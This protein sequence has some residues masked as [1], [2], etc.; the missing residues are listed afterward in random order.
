MALIWRFG[1]LF[2]IFTRN[3]YAIDSQYPVCFILQGLT[4]RPLLSLS[5]SFFF[6]VV[7]VYRKLGSSCLLKRQSLDFSASLPLASIQDDLVAAGCS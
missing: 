4:R 3:R 7:F 6:P 2:A 5:F 1:F